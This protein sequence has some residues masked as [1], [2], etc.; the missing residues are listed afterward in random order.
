MST[1]QG[2]VRTLVHSFLLIY[3]SS[4]NSLRSYRFSFH[5]QE[6]HSN[7]IFTSQIF[8]IYTV[9]ALLTHPGTLGAAYLMVFTDVSSRRS[10]ASIITSSSQSLFDASLSEK[11]KKIKLRGRIN[12]HT[13]ENIKMQANNLS[14]SHIDTPSF[15]KL[16]QS[17]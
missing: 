9:P 16:T 7:F 12:I 6:N 14:S 11:E 15:P 8:Y 2:G 5:F 4:L 17:L 1:S 10:K 13:F 3:P